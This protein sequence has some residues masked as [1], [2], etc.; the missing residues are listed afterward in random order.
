MKL[1]FYQERNFQKH[2]T[3]RRYVSM[4]S[5]AKIKIY[6]YAS[7]IIDKTHDICISSLFIYQ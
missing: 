2:L 4:L 6:V 5:W 1:K 7:Q 3:Y